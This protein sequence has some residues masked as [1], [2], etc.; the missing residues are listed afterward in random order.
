MLIVG[1]IFLIKKSVN[2]MSLVDSDFY[3]M[4]FVQSN[5]SKNSKK[6]YFDYKK[7]STINKIIFETREPQY[8][9]I[10]GKLVFQSGPEL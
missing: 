6:I 8:R 4:T 10:P 2:Q 7:N 3:K 1:L 9:E 5:F